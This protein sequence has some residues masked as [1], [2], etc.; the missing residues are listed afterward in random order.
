LFF[1]RNGHDQPRQAAPSSI[2][3]AAALKAMELTSQRRGVSFP[4]AEIPSSTV[5]AAVA[6]SSRTPAEVPDRLSVA[7]A[8]SVPEKDR[9][10]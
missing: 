5:R 8:D 9:A 1:T 2:T 4:A 3:A 10:S 6:V 7:L